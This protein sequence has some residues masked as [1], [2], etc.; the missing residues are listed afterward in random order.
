MTQPTEQAEHRFLKSGIELAVLPITERPLAT[1]AIRLAGGYAG[2]DPA[3]LGVAHLLTEAIT[4]GTA[5]HDGRGLNDAFDEIGAAHTAATGRETITFSCLCLSEFIDRAL[6]LHAEMIRTPTFPDD[7]CE[8]AVD[9]TRQAL[10]ALDD[11]PH[12]LAKKYLHRQAYGEPLG[13]HAYGEPETLERIG[14]KQIVDHW[15]RHFS[16]ARMQVAVAGSVEPVAVADLL[17]REFEGFGQDARTRAHDAR[18]QRE[19]TPER[20]SFS[21]NF[22]PGRT[23]YP[24]DCE[25][26]Q[27]AI[28]FPGAAATD[29]DEAVERVVIGVLAGG[30]S[31]R[32]WSAVRENQGL[33]YWVGAGN[34]RPRTAGMVH[35]GASSTPQHVEKTYATLLREINRL[36]DNV[37][38]QEIDRAVTGIIASTQTY[39]DLT[40]AK[41]IRLANDLFY[42]SRPIRLDEKL[43]KVKAVTVADVQEYLHTHPR[44]E[45]SVITLGPTE[46]NDE[47][48]VMNDEQ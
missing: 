36:A 28:C 47:L 43:A 27:I 8:V 46:L 20:P 12:E 24:K 11:D 39:G 16:A 45:L 21:L 10:A 17:E 44:D 40:R 25:Q 35:L 34:D 32:L 23:H 30:M 15:R 2:E 13:R 1:M 38:D 37:T 3:H 9:L 14:R 6:E 42:Y 48:Q 18:K 5:K 26:E 19:L 4:K 31:S 29:E 33:V 41:A 7:A 22:S